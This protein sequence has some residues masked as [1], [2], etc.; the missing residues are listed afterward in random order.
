MACSRSK[1]SSQST[2]PLAPSNVRLFHLAAAFA[3][4]FGLCAQEPV[5]RWGPPATNDFTERTIEKLLD[6]GDQGFVLLRVAVDATTVR[7]YRLERYDKTL[8]LVGT[9]EVAFN[10]GI[11]GDAYFLDDIVARAMELRSRSA[12]VLPSRLSRMAAR[13]G[14]GVSSHPD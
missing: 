7:H 2:T 5:Y 9:T 6:L 8:Q 10:G 11:M 12:A 3:V 13:S 1:R 14:S 4:G